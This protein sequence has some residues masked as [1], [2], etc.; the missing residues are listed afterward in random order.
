MFVVVPVL[1]VVAATWRTTLALMSFRR[2][3]AGTFP[4]GIADGGTSVV[5]VPAVT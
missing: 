2:P 5:E 3:E 1:G 4:E